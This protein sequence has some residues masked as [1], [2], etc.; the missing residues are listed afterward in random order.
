[1]RSYHI[2]Q[3]LF[4]KNVFQLLGFFLVWVSHNL[5]QCSLVIN[6]PG[7]FQSSAIMINNALCICLCVLSLVFCPWWNWYALTNWFLESLSN[8]QKLFL[9]GQCW[10]NF[11]RNTVKYLPWVFLVDQEPAFSCWRSPSRLF[12]RSF[13]SAAWIPLFF[14]IKLLC[15][16]LPSRFAHLLRVS[17]W[18]E[19]VPGFRS[20]VTSWWCYMNFMWMLVRSPRTESASLTVYVQSSWRSGKNWPWPQ[21]CCGA[22]CSALILR[23]GGQCSERLSV[24]WQPKPRRQ[25]CKGKMMPFNLRLLKKKTNSVSILWFA[26]P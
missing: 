6:C 15:W 17:L 1:M 13:P 20:A 4:S 5:L 24:W 22:P 23:A 16:K 7:C 11:S 21:H 9:G 12:P 19:Q 2:T 26:F 3:F 8:F 14:S 18:G 10:C 25:L